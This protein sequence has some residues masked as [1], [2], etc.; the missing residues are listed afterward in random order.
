MKESLEKQY[1]KI[2]ELEERFQH[3]MHAA[4]IT[5]TVLSVPSKN[6]GQTI[7]QTA[8]EENC[9]C[10]V[11]GTR[12]RSLLKKALL[13]SVSDYVVKNADIPVI[14]VRKKDGQ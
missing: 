12:G 2:T 13:G 4:K 14:V 8:Q 6:A 1:S 3:K 11:M 9:F 7:L 5:G 10:I